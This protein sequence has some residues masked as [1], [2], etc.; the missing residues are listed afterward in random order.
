MAQETETQT[1]KKNYEVLLTAYAT[2]VVL[3]AESEEKAIEYAM[4]A[5]TRGDFEI[6]EMKVERELKTERELESA[7]RHAECVAE[8]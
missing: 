8:P 7:K 1:E 4:D 2:V 6:D 5:V 3:E